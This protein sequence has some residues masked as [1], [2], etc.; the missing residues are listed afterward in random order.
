M[1]TVAPTRSVPL[2]GFSC[3][4]SIRKSVVL[5]APLGPMMPTMPPGG[6]RKERFSKSTLSPNDFESPS[7]SI[8]RSPSGRLAGMKIS[9]S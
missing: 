5:P 2:S 3:P 8:T 1:S 7:P 4:T 9:T 6:S